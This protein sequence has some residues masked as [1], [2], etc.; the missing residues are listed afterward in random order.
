MKSNILINW[1]ITFFG[2]MGLLLMIKIAGE[3]PP[4][5]YESIMLLAL[6]NILYYVGLIYHN[7]QKR[8]KPFH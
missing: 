7:H 6:T 1:S 4:S 3:H 2:W 5:F 8:I